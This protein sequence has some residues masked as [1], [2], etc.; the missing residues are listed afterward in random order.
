MYGN[1]VNRTVTFSDEVEVVHLPATDIDLKID[2]NSLPRGSLLLQCEVLMVKSPRKEEGQ[3]GQELEA[4][5]RVRVQADEFWGQADVI[6]YNEDKDQL[7]LTAAEGNYASLYR[8]K[9]QGGPVEE[10]KGKQI[11]YYRRTN[12]YQVNGGV[13]VRTSN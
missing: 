6:T 2:M 10:I 12:D 4:K 1:E 7:V 9:A 8:S 5:K 3:G 11:I 13:G